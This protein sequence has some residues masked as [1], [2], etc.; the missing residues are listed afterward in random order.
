[1]RAALL[2]RARRPAA[3][4]G[5]ALL[6]LGAVRNAAAI[7]RFLT[8][9]FGVN[10]FRD[11]YMGAKIG[12]SAGWSH[13]YDL[14][15]QRSVLQSVMPHSPWLPYVNPPPVAWLA[16]PLSALPFPAAFAVWAGLGAL[17]LLA[18]WWLLA[19]PGRWS[20]TIHLLALAGLYSAGYAVKTGQVLPLVVLAVSASWVLLHRDRQVAA[21]LVLVLIDLKPQVAWLVPICLLLAGRY[22][23]VGAW[24]AGSAILASWSALTLGPAGVAGF[25]HALR[26][27][28][29]VPHGPISLMLALPP[30]AA[31]PAGA[32]AVLVAALASRRTR[33]DGPGGAIAAGVAASLLVASH[34]NV[35]DLTLLV[36]AAWMV[37][38]EGRPAGRAVFLVSGYAAIQLVGGFAV[39]AL[40]WEVAWLIVLSVPRS[41][42]EGEGARQAASARSRLPGVRPLFAP[43]TASRPRPAAARKE[44]LA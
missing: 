22:R 39:P 40:A 26:Y 15:L 28:L 38:R 29:G 11:Y 34:L 6:V 9:E 27:D 43:T 19:P 42:G 44:P 32:G 17:C 5:V 35:Q 10:D 13:L 33:A 20:R 12:L 24:A 23:T 21:G 7:A 36:P 3:A 16:A 41:A 1:M 4:A 2:E 37:A 14:G 25:V 8:A 31:Y 30:A 18:S